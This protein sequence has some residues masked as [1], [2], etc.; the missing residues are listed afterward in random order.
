MSRRTDRRGEEQ[1]THVGLAYIR[2]RTAALSGRRSYGSGS[3]TTRRDAAG[4]D[5]WYGQWRAGG[6]RITRKLGPKRRPGTR[7]G[8][9]RSQAERELRR[10]IEAELATPLAARLSLAQ[11]GERYLRHIRSLRRAP[12]TLQDYEII[13]RRHLA[14]FFGERPLERVTSADVAAYADRKL[15]AGLAHNTVRNHLNLLYGVFVHAVKRGWAPANPVAG[16]DRPRPERVDPDIRFLDEPELEALLRAVPDDGF[17]PSDR[18]VYLTAAMSGLRQGELLA[19]RWRDV[20]WS[21]GV[22][23]VRRKHYR[24]EFGQPKSK[25]SSRA[26]PMADRL[27]AELEHHFQRSSYRRD[28][29]LVFGHPQL[30]TVRDASKLRRR[31]LAAARAAG[32]RPARFH[33]LR[34]TFGTRMA[35]AGAPLRAIQEWMGHRDYKTTEIYAD[36]APDPS[37]GNVWAQ[38]AFARTGLEDL[39]LVA[40]SVSGGNKT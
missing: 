29:D 9:T 31:F 19:L 25:R 11:A 23:R 14:P 13:L 35:A 8:L 32:L 17:G 24:G 20:D 2:S 38:H 22:I 12:S 27:A 28:D 33:D 30:G 36:Y 6:R 5:S 1:W 7:E 26:V 18:T 15:G 16:V 3:L 37:Q 34:H 39:D 21:V 40:G 4:V 10:R